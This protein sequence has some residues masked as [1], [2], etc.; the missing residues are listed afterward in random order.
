MNRAQFDLFAPPRSLYPGGWRP[1]DRAMIVWMNGRRDKP[2]N[3]I[4]A[5]VTAR[6]GDEITVECVG[7]STPYQFTMP[8][9]GFARPE[10]ELQFWLEGMAG[11]TLAQIAGMEETA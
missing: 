4:E 9:S 11:M 1:G 8:A 3:A 10:W 7:V 5:K 6:Q 2:M